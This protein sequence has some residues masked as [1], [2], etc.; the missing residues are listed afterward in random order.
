MGLVPGLHWLNK[1][2]GADL[3]FKDSIEKTISDFDRF[4]NFI[5]SVKPHLSAK[6][7]EIGK[8]DSFRLN[9]TLYYKKDV[10]KPNYTQYQYPV[11]DLMFALALAGGLYVKANEKGKAVLVKTSA[12]ESF[13][14]LNIYEKYVFLL[15][16][17]W[18]KYEFDIKY[19][20]FLSIDFFYRFLTE[21]A[22]SKKSQWVVKD[23]NFNTFVH[24][25]KDSAFFCHLNFFGFGEYK[26]YDDK[27]AFFK[28]SVK[29]F[30]V[31]EFGIYASRFL[32]TDALMTWNNMF[33]DY[34]ISQM[35]KKI[36]PQK[37]KGPFEIFKR[38]FPEGEV[39]NT[40]VKDE[41]DRSGVYTF[42]VSLYSDLWRKINI[43]HKHYLSDL[44]KAIQEAFDFD[45]DHLYA[46][47]IGGKRKTGKAIYCSYVEEEGKTADEINIADLR[48]F[49]GQK[50]FYLFDF[51]D[52]WWFDI[53]LLKIDK[54]SPLPAQ[55]VI[56]GSEGE[57]LDQYPVRE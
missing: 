32:V 51:G 2:K 12:N 4:N 30:I 42:K 57:S 28:D 7:G 44:H 25:S 45:N 34:L 49:R 26:L 19:S 13:K 6:R 50:I 24:Y 14:S 15:Q 5:E 56:V 11:I 47:Y 27:E 1:Q 48:L 54:E 39:N 22:D 53:K 38:L 52:E 41:F 46:F 36:K 8:K 9:Q 17:Y 37:D 55:P 23:N 35:K 3:Y 21:L 43:S 16:T 10:S 18:T 40:V 29:D 33:L 31:N 20:G